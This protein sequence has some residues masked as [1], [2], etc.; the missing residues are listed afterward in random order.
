M[1]VGKLDDLIHVVN[2]PCSIIYQ[3]GELSSALVQ[4]MLKLVQVRPQETNFW[5]QGSTVAEKCMEMC[6]W[7]LSFSRSVK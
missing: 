5:F 4:F 7:L 6:V 2:G 1:S 3:G